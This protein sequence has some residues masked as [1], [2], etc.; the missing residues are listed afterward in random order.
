MQEH[1]YRIKSGRFVL[2]E[3]ADQNVKVK[4][5]RLLRRAVYDDMKQPCPAKATLGYETVLEVT[6]QAKPASRWRWRLIA[7]KKVIQRGRTTEDG[8]SRGLL[9]A[10]DGRIDYIIVVQQPEM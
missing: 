4:V 7:D 8:I 6:Y 3:E 5:H 9:I 10:H 1:R 2:V